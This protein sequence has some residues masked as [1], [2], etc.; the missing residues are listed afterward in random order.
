M[1]TFPPEMEFEWIRQPKG[2]GALMRFPFAFLIGVAAHV[3][4]RQPLREIVHRYE[5]GGIRIDAPAVGS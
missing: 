4:R 5:G 3:S 1:F 2:R